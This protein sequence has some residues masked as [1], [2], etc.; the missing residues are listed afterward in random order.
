MINLLEDQGV[1][2]ETV[3]YYQTPLECQEL[4]G[5]TSKLEITV[6]YLLRKNE[7]IYPHLGLEQRE[8]CDAELVDLTVRHPDLIQR[9][10]V[11]RG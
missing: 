2:F 7:Q 1:D 6:R 9:P 4:A 3:S 11:V 8:P 10:I 5:L